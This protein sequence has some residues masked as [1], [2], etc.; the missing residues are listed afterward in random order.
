MKYQTPIIDLRG[1]PEMEAL[2]FMGD[3]HTMGP[4]LRKQIHKLHN[5]IVFICGDCGLGFNSPIYHRGEFEE[6]QHMCNKR[7]IYICL[8]RGNHDDLLYWNYR[9]VDKLSYGIANQND[10]V[11][12]VGDYDLVKTDFGNVLSIGGGIS[13]DRRSRVIGKSYWPNEYVKS[14]DVDSFNRLKDETIDIVCS[15]T[16]PSFANTINGKGGIVDQFSEYDKCLID[17]LFEERVLM[18]QIYRI[19]ITNWHP[20]EWFFGHFHHS[21]FMMTEENVKFLGLDC[22]EI[23]QSYSSYK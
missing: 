3:S 7:N 18:D 1:L 23:K 4:D 2:L 11:I 16:A 14:F 13:I 21:S 5:S 8:I 10:R 22:F 17:E 15:H 9:H 19:I 20:K 12:L 6:L